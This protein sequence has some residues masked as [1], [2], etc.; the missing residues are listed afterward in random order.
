MIKWQED[1]GA[2]LAVTAVNIIG[3][4]TIPQYHD[5]LIYGM[6]A[7]GYFGMMRNWGGDFVKNVGIASLPL[8]AEK[9]YNRITTGTPATRMAGRVTR[10]PAPAYSQEFEGLKLE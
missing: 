6:T 7:L 9:L 8:T 10:Y 2:P 4:K 3:R 5:W 1:I